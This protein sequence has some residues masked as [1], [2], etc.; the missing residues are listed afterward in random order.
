MCA[1][2]FTMYDII[3]AGAAW[4]RAKWSKNASP[5]AATDGDEDGPTPTAEA[6]ALGE[7]G[8]GDPIG[9]QAVHPEPDRVL[10][11]AFVDDP[12]VDGEALLVR[13]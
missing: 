13:G 10:M 9:D 3:P 7:P 8:P 4:V 6:P 11:P 12:G 2:C 1:V 5:V